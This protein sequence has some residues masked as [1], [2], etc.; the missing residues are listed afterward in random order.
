VHERAHAPAQTAVCVAANSAAIPAVVGCED[1]A[2]WTKALKVLLDKSVP[3]CF[4]SMN[5]EELRLDSDA[6]R[7]AGAIILHSG[8]NTFGSLVPFRDIEAAPDEFYY[9]N[10]WVTCFKGREG[11]AAASTSGSSSSA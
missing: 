10:G 2:S 4:T 7:A 1:Q 5:A 6:L 8:R 11:A 9:Q 3:C